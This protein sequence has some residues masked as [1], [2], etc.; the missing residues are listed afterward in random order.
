MYQGTELWDFSLVDPDNRRPVDYDLRRSML[1]RN[2][3]P[4]LLVTSWHTGQIKQA[5][6][7]R[8]LRLRERRSALFSAGNYTPLRVEGP[9]EEHA[10]AFA[11]EHDDS[12]VITVVTR[13]SAKA[14]LSEAP[15]MKPEFWAGTQLHVPCP[16]SGRRLRNSLRD[17]NP[18]FT[19]PEDGCLRLED[20]LAELPVALL[21]G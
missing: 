20:I 19:V 8:A 14:G 16:W 21:E 3:S 7:H 9:A 17:S 11:R 13:L 12:V 1:Q 15:V 18:E 4:E 2:T 6:L 10:L 5:I